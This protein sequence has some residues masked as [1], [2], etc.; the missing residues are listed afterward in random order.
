[1]HLLHTVDRF[2]RSFSFSPTLSFFLFAFMSPDIKICY[3]NDKYMWFFLTEWGILIIFSVEFSLCYDRADRAWSL[4]CGCK[5][6]AEISSPFCLQEQRFTLQRDLC[7]VHFSFSS[8]FHTHTH[9]H[10]AH[11][12]VSYFSLKMGRLHDLCRVKCFFLFTLTYKVCRPSSYLNKF[13]IEIDKITTTVLFA[14]PPSY[15]DQ[16]I[17]LQWTNSKCCFLTSD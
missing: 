2:I 8:T 4:L 5:R 15:R 3:V 9:T 7:A 14:L 10:N 1:M 12:E 11:T 17:S 13:N 16:A 6:E